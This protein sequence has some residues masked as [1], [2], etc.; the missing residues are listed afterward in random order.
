MVLKVVIA[1]ANASKKESLNLLGFPTA[2]L[3][4]LLIKSIVLHCSNTSGLLG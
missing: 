2:D 4:A 3:L 1:Y